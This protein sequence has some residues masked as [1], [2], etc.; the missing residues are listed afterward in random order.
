MLEHNQSTYI[1]GEERREV[2]VPPPLQTT[3]DGFKRLYLL[4]SPLHIVTPWKKLLTHEPLGHT[5]YLNYGRISNCERAS[6]WLTCSVE[7]YSKQALFK[8]QDLY[9]TMEPCLL[10]LH[11]IPMPAHFLSTTLLTPLAGYIMPSGVSSWQPAVV[12]SAG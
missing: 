6:P 12:V 5:G 3:P 4:K 10:Q 9:K 2:S 1:S 8:R 7:I 11:L